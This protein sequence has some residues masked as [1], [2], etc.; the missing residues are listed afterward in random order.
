MVA[1][2]RIADTE[3]IAKFTVAKNGIEIRKIVTLNYKGGRRT[4]SLHPDS[5][6]QMKVILAERIHNV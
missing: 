5:L 6:E 3:A 1:R 4:I 2:V